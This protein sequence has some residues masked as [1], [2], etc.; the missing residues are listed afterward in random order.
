MKFATRAL[1]TRR[2]AIA[3]Y[4]AI[5]QQCRALPLPSADRDAVQNIA[6]NRFRAERNTI[7][8]RRVKLA[9][10][11]GYAAVDVLDGA[12]AGD[13]ASTARLREYLAAVPPQLTTR[14]APDANK[15]AATKTKP[16]FERG[17]DRDPP[18]AH[19]FESVFP[20]EAVRGVRKVP[21]MAN[22]NGFPFVRWKKPQPKSLS[23]VLRQNIQ[24]RQRRLN[25]QVD[26]ADYWVPLAA[27]EDRWEELVEQ[28]LGKT[29]DELGEADGRVL[30]VTSMR[31]ELRKVNKLIYEQIV[32][33]KALTD[34]MQAI[35]DRERELA[36]EEKRQ[37]EQVL[38]KDANIEGANPTRVETD[39][40]TVA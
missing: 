35:V 2:T 17:A 25:L 33:T 36:T 6:R 19:K 14:A 20:R 37:R 12:A 21:F 23:R 3:L 22:A 31:E 4:R 29:Q 5:L 24:R 9:F 26:L 16:Q 27:Y 15:T 30:F 34:R 40:T 1:L 10:H 39:L 13:A 8:P 11:A 18:A 7:S 28:Q 32:R 38:L